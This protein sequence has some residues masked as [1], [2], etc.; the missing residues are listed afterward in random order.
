MRSTKLFIAAGVTA[1]AVFGAAGEDGALRMTG[2]TNDVRNYTISGVMSVA[3]TDAKISG[4]MTQKVLKVEDNGNLTLQ[5]T[6]NMTIE[7]NGQELPPQVAVTVTV[8]K[9]DGTIVEIRSAEIGAS[10]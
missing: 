8:M 4:K 3:G 6:E 7:V 9:P 2:I 10:V 1:L 5:D